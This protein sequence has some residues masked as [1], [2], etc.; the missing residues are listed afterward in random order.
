MSLLTDIEG[1]ILFMHSQGK[2]PRRIQVPLRLR[3][4]LEFSMRR[5]QSA[6]RD[7]E[8]PLHIMGVMVYFE[9]ESVEIESDSGANFG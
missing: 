8:M 7:D 4:E 3:P 1:Q 5:S 2:R 6:R 9:G